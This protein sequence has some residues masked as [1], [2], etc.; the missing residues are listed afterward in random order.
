M[1]RL[2]SGDLFLSKCTVLVNPVN[3]VA[4][5]GAG[6]AKQF[7]AKFKD[8][9]YF[10][11]YAEDC[12]RKLLKPGY[13]TVWNQYDTAKGYGLT[14]INFPTKDDW[15]NPSKIEWIDSGLERLRLMINYPAAIAI[16]ALGCGLGGLDKTEVKNLILKHFESY[17]G[18]VELYGF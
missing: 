12:A 18:L 2:C 17:P 14:V 1:I 7:K 8:T 9:P 4:V 3:C 6:L 10:E 11:R 5:M 15:K 13:P 16:P